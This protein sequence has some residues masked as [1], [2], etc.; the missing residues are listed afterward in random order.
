MRSIKCK[1]NARANLLENV[2]V[3][4]DGVGLNVDRLRVVVLPD[5]KDHAVVI[6]DNGARATYLFASFVDFVM[7]P[8]TALA[9][10]QDYN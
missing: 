6:V 8:T 10:L 4:V 7:A 5:I 1:K 2:V 3:I 9:A